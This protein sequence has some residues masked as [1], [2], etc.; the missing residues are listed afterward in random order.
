MRSVVGAAT[1]A[2]NAAVR[3]ALCSL[4]SFLGS[5]IRLLLRV[6]HSLK[7]EPPMRVY[8][9]SAGVDIYRA[10]SFNENIRVSKEY[11]HSM[12][13]ERHVVEVFDTQPHRDTCCK[14]GEVP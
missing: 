8:R 5:S 4:S 11:S 2:S 7:P 6:A 1:S 10:T 3:H 9:M 12:R 14:R 13:F